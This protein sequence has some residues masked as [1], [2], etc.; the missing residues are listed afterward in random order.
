M[1]WCVTLPPGLMP[2]PRV[3]SVFSWSA[4]VLSGSSHALSC[5]LAV[6]PPSHETDMRPYQSEVSLVHDA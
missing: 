5:V 1:P 6:P 3:E 4:P 2:M